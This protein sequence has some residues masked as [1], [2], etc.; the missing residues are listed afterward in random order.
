MYVYICGY[1]YLCV[2][3]GIH[4]Y[5]YIEKF[6]RQEEDIFE[7]SD[8]LNRQEFWYYWYT[9]GRQTKK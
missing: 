7:Q 2:Y 5:V 1:V 8:D 4:K 6:P 3:I 9:R